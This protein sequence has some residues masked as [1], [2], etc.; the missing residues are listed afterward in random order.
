MKLGAGSYVVLNES[1][2]W[3]FNINEENPAYGIYALPE[4]RTVG[5]SLGYGPPNENLRDLVTFQS[6]PGRVG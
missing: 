2:P 4:G 5:P 6:S 3:T 1:L